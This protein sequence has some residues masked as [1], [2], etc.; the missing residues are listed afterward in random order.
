MFSS[1]GR[2]ISPSDVP[3]TRGDISCPPRT[4]QRNDSAIYPSEELIRQHQETGKR[5]FLRARR[6]RLGCGALYKAEPGGVEGAIPAPNQS[7]RKDLCAMAVFT[8]NT[9][10]GASARPEPRTVTYN[11]DSLTEAAH[12]SA[13]MGSRVIAQTLGLAA[14]LLAIVALLMSW[15]FTSSLAVSWGEVIKLGLI[16]S[17]LVA[18]MSGLPVAA[19]MMARSYPPEARYCMR[20]WLVVLAVVAASAVV[21]TWRLE[22]PSDKAAPSRLV[23]QPLG[24]PAVRSLYMTA[25][26]WKDSSGCT[27]PRTLYH[28]EVCGE[29][30]WTLAARGV[31]ENRDVAAESAPLDWSPAATL[32]VTSLAEGATRQAIVLLLSLIA[33]A[34]AGILGRWATLATAESYRLGE[35][36]ASALPLP[37]MTAPAPV[38]SRSIVPP[39]DP[40]ALWAEGRLIPDPDGEVS[41]DALWHDYAETMRLNGLQGMTQARFFNAMSDLAKRS[42]GRVAKFK[43]DAIRYKGIRLPDGA[44]AGSSAGMNGDSSW[45]N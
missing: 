10:F 11:A 17:A 41:A 16:G 9:G 40:F 22:A 8:N 36:Q 35:G 34:G 13:R 19:A 7:A 45:L 27:A 18:A 1:G 6:L 30:R 25:E 32:G 42:G 38:P 14:W 43:N 20:A 5:V 44:G 12:R 39:A 28:E 4:R 37:S 2:S 24:S 29:Y 33:T 3:S 26:L 21:F 23:A 31:S 15:A